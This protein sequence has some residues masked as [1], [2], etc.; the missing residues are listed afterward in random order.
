MTD[1]AAPPRPAPLPLTDAQR[2]SIERTDLSMAVTSG[3]GCGK[4]FVLARRYLQVLEDLAL[5]EA[6]S[7]V[8]AVTFTEKAAIEMRQ[9][10]AALIRQQLPG[11]ADP[12]RQLLLGEWLDR[13]GGARISTIH[14]FCSHL[15]R[16]Y[17][18]EAGV[19]PA[20]AV[21]ADEF[22]TRALTHEACSTALLAALAG[23]APAAAELVE[24]F[25]HDQLLAMLAT[26]VAERWRWQSVDYAAPADTLARWE[27]T[28]QQVCQQAWAALDAD[29]L[30]AEMDWL[31]ALAC[32]NPEDKL[33]VHLREQ[34]A[35]AAQILAGPE[36][37]NEVL[38]AALKPKAGGIG[39]AKAW[40]ADVK[41][42]RHRCKALLE[43]LEGLGQL[44][45]P[46]NEADALA[47]ELLATLT[48]LAADACGR[49]AQAK[50]RAGV[51]DFTDLQLLSRDLLR[52]NPTVRQAV[53]ADIHQLL[54]DEFQDTDALQRELLW[55]AAGCQTL[56][57]PEGKIFFVGD[58]KQSIYRFR[59]AE[60]EVFQAA[61]A[62]LSQA[63]R[64]N[65]DRNFRTHDG[66]VTLTNVLFGPLMG[67]AYEPLVAHRRTRP[68]EPA[69]EL[70]LAECDAKARRP[71]QMRA[72]ARAVAERIARMVAAEERRVW[73]EARQD[74]RPVR[75]RDIAILL[76]QM[77]NTAPLEEA[78]QDAG[79][80][81]YVVSGAGLYRQQEVY[82]LLNALRA[83]DNPLDD[84]ALAG[85]LRG[86]MVGLDDHA[87][88]HLAL[89]AEPPYRPRLRD[90]AV[91][92]RLTEPVRKR[93]VRAAGLLETLSAYKDAA[94]I[95]ALIERLLAET[96]YEA[97]LL[98]Q[99]HGQRRCGNLQRVL[100]QARAAQ[101]AGATLGAFTAYISQLAIEQV[102]AEQASLEAEA[103]D[104]V[105]IMTVHK[106]KGLEFPV[107]V[108]AD[109]GHQG[110]GGSGTLDVR[111]PCG[112][113]LRLATSDDVTP[114]SARLA[115][116]FDAQADLAE[117]LR[118]FYV[119]VTRHRDYL[120]LAGAVKG[121]LAD[122]AELGAKNT[123]L[124]RLDEALGLGGRLPA[125][126]ISLDGELELAVNVV[127]PQRA[128]RNEQ[129]SVLAGLLAEVDG[130]EALAQ[131]LAEPVDFADE[132]ELPWL[133]PVRTDGLE[134][135]P[136]TA[137][138][139][140]EFCPACFH[141]HYELRV[142]TGLLRRATRTADC[143]AESDASDAD[144]PGSGSADWGGAIAF[145]K[146]TD[147]NPWGSR[148]GGTPEDQRSPGSVATPVVLDPT[149]AGTVFHRCLE[150]LDF[151]ADATPSP[152]ALVRQA[153]E[154]QALDADPA[155][156]AAELSA[157]LAGL[158][159]HPLWAT[160]TAARQTLREL[161]FVTRV[162]RLE[163][164]GVIDLL[165]QDAG[166]TWHVVDYKSDR[167]GPEGPAAHAGRYELQ[168]L[169]YVEAARRHLGPA[170]GPIDATLY[171]LRPAQAHTFTAE[172]LSA[173]A[174]A[175]RLAD[176]AESLAHCRRTNTWPARRDAACA[177]C[178]FAALCR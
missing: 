136:P 148:S 127:T 52:D 11:E 144:D 171:F 114:Q 25:S 55:L 75:P 109:L 121:S 164:N 22:Q 30:R 102:R 174:A 8:A 58:A 141:W 15:L 51:L 129:P 135:L 86:G 111:G 42:I 107:V 1:A 108:L 63:G 168:M 23:E 163:L 103:G 110:R 177:H 27:L 62:A 117:D 145:S 70:L 14:G 93:L 71:A 175:D 73:D 122:G 131:R 20:F 81:Y 53:A 60:V 65:L 106:A 123:H 12:H 94:P 162:G 26:L 21:L 138:A 83:I 47:A 10:I 149:Q 95:D 176:L 160:L 115:K 16:A 9:R 134:R 147:D 142:P 79:V 78:L 69:A 3:A 173:G 133:G 125:E 105:R 137:L 120:V 37:W 140:L 39:S 132:A 166:G 59:G 139:E 28:R 119:A 96:G 33:A 104:V 118:A 76:P 161:E 17:A 31:G 40:D 165:V 72:E 87:L 68:P 29:A 116:W 100:A 77:Q 24:H 157:M 54:I 128:R 57:P 98:G 43:A 152:A 35:L 66:G 18:I 34:L 4:T 112:L 169:L 89:A 45:G 126:R 13:L 91:L 82:D 64:Q 170:A 5:P 84:V 92:E 130:P 90:L 156:L 153:M 158:R 172:S 36:H 80:D 6:V 38:F 88:L 124:R 67:E 99:P 50:R 32:D 154:E 155:P 49:F 56:Q 85:F 159:G 150:L 2:A 48:A 178:H 74:W 151:S 97:V 101:S 7:R 143:G 44:A 19:D 46:I 146:P 41:E 61:R 113:T 167:V